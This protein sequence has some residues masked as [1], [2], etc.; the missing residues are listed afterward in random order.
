MSITYE[1]YTI[2]ITIYYIV[3]GKTLYKASTPA[4]LRRGSLLEPLLPLQGPS[5]LLKWII[6]PQHIQ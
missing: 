3:P 6:C 1:Y 4:G 2:T 5:M